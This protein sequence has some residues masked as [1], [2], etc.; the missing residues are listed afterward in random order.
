MKPRSPRPVG[1]RPPSVALA[2]LAALW[3]AC[4]GPQP[5]AAQQQPA[6]PVFR[7][8]VDVV[9]VDVNVV[10][11]NGRPIRGLEPEDFA[12]AVDGLP[13]RVL[14]A[15]FVDLGTP[16]D[17]PPSPPP[18]G[19]FSTNEGVRSGRMLLIVV[20]EGALRPGA[21]RHVVRAA[22]RL[23]DGLGAGDR[24]GLLTMPGGGPQ[25]EFTTEHAR[26]RNALKH[27]NGRA[28]FAGRR[29]SLTEAFAFDDGREAE[30]VQVVQRECGV[31]SGPELDACRS[32][33]EGEAGSVAQGVRHQ[34]QVS[35]KGLSLL[36]EG[37]RQVEG[38]KTVVLLTQALRSERVGELR[39]LAVAAA[40][41]RVAFYGIEIDEAGPDAAVQARASTGHEDTDLVTRD[42]YRLASLTRGDVFRSAGSAGPFDRIVREMSGY[43]LI[44]FE[45]EGSD[46]DG[47]DH[48]IEVSVHKANA[49]VRARRSLPLVASPTRTDA[50]DGLAATLRSSTAATELPLRV[51]TYALQ[52]P[53]SPGKVRLLVSAEIGRGDVPPAGL[54]IG[55]VLADATGR[56]VATSAHQIDSEAGSGD[57]AP[58]PYLGLAVVDPGVYTLRLAAV[59]ARGRRGS[60]THRVQGAL[61]TAGG[62]EMAD[63]MLAPPADR[64][65]ASLRPVVEARG[66]GAALAALV[67]LY[68]PEAAFEGAG[69]SIEVAVDAAGP[70]LLQVPATSVPGSGSRRVVQSLVPISL[71]PPGPYVARAVLAVRGKSTGQVVR[72][73]RVTA[74]AAGAPSA[75]P[76]AGFVPASLQFDANA[77]LGAEL[78]APSLDGLRRTVGSLP[79]NVSRAVDDAAAGRLDSLLDG[80]GDAQATSMALSFLRGVGLLA[81]GQ[82]A[83]ALALFRAAVR[84]RPDFVPATVY[85]AA[86]AAAQGY[87][88]EAAGAWNTALLQDAGSPLVHVALADA[89]LRLG[90]AAAALD[91]LEPAVTTWPDDARLR[92]RLGLAYAFEGRAAQ[93][94]PLLEA[95]LEASPEDTDSMFAVLRLL[96]E[97]LRTGGTGSDRPRFER[98]ARAY[99]DA[100]APRHA[101][102][103]QWLRTMESSGAP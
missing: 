50:R 34:S 58:I 68:G 59:D 48:V 7:A 55:F 99:V 73:F 9:A 17:P 89:H 54:A 79:A 18:A 12:L 52:E 43:Y 42:L 69:V 65:G 33:V 63:L 20:D 88:Q 81:R 14:S 22:D 76:I 96:Y 44:G 61:T 11:G 3:G 5:A 21:G 37:L 86:A 87:D 83:G 39:E 6:A 41:A 78:L 70:A 45:P 57:P 67:E 66:D 94:L 93:A 15:E 29:I 1:R 13:R 36:M 84:E 77:F 102:V 47:R 71:L 30:W 92:H 56:P 40:A 46:R 32:D 103:A 28:S 101:L 16:E 72:S 31:L 25:I 80:L 97:P 10:D 24:A 74:L 85:L 27:V 95:H 38:P 100:R 64:P 49:T 23:L 91:V 4:A 19:D 8:E 35:M 90:Q 2:S 82:H 75:S 51:A 60:V 53:S 62:L 26:V 98:Y